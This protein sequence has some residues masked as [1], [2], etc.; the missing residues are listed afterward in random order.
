MIANGLLLAMLCQ[1]DLRHRLRIMWTN[2]IT[3]SIIIVNTRGDSGLP[4][5]MA[6]QTNPDKPKGLTPGFNVIYGDQDM[7]VLNEVVSDMEKSDVLQKKSSYD[8]ALEPLPTQDVK[9][10]MSVDRY[11]SKEMG[12]M[13]SKVSHF[14]NSCGLLVFVKVTSSVC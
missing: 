13:K 1:M 11:C 3:F 10:L 9:C 6:L 8:E 2:I 4:S 7:M 12:K 14:I 5:T